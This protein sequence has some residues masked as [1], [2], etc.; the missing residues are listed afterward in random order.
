M[1][2]YHNFIFLSDYNNQIKNCHTFLESKVQANLNDDDNEEEEVKD[3][4]IDFSLKYFFGSIIGMGTV[5][6][7]L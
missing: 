3:D 1:S 6:R 4:K 5:V 7:P 2:A